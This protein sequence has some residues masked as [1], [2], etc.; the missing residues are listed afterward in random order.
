MKCNF[1]EESHPEDMLNHMRMMHP[2]SLDA[3][4]S[5]EYYFGLKPVTQEMHDDDHVC[6]RC[7]KQFVRGMVYV[8]V[9]EA[10]LGDMPIMS[11]ICGGCFLAD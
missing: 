9:P 11:V 6:E 7:D 5:T 8:E 2:D 3:T 10:M 1:C 4:Q